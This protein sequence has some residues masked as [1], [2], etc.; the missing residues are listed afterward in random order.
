MCV[1]A[2]NVSS[3]LLLVIPDMEQQASLFSGIFSSNIYV[4]KT[5]TQLEVKV[6]F[7]KYNFH[8]PFLKQLLL[9]K[10]YNKQAH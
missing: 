2:G 10:L 6:L 8:K 4:I 3:A 7:N 1:P 9:T 5:M